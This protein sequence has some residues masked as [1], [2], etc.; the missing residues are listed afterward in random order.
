M[1]TPNN[2]ARQNFERL[3]SDIKHGQLDENI[4]PFEKEAAEGWNESGIAMNSLK[5]LDKKFRKTTSSATIYIT[6][7]CLIIGIGVYLFIAQKK[8]E[9]KVSE[10]KIVHYTI[11]KSEIELPEYII[12][13]QE[14]EPE[15]QI[16]VKKVKKEQ[17]MYSKQ[18]EGDKSQQ[19]DIPLP[20]H[21]LE[22]LPVK[23]EQR[24]SVIS[25]Q[26]LAKERM[27]H[28]FKTIDYSSYRANKTM[29]VEQYILTGIPANYENELSIEDET[30]IQTS[31]TSYNNYLDK[32]MSYVNKGKWKIALSRFEEILHQYPDDLNARFYSGWCYFNLGN[33]S[34]ACLNFSVCLQL[35]YSN[36]NE[37][38]EW[39]LAESRLAN[40]EK[41]DAKEL[42]T[43]IKNQKGFYSKEA[44][45]VLKTWR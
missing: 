18:S 9:L 35:D 17:Q 24:P 16:T 43:K 19:L 40:G 39:Y 3:L 8:Q 5:K 29:K 1:K 23:L 38:A 42:F 10:N 27:T 33:Y 7:T 31:S 12:A 15:K 22:P 2:I 37:E 32:S 14:I 4:D 45:K 34:E 36:F 41:A 13:L 30:P 20:M 28:D 21:V 44:E 6:A 11:D 26:T 25:K